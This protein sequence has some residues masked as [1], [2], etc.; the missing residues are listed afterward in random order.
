MFSQQVDASL[1]TY[2]VGDS[3]WFRYDETTAK[4][5]DIFANQ[6]IDTAVYGPMDFYREQQRKIYGKNK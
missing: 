5:G 3:V 1:P 2:D 6:V 4:Y